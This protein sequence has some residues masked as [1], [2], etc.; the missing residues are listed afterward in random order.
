MDRRPAPTA[1]TAAVLIPAAFGLG[2]VNLATYEGWGGISHWN[3]FVGTLEMGG[4]GTLFEPRLAD[5]VKY[6]VAA[7]AGFGSIRNPDDRV[8]S[9]L[10]A[11]QMYQ[12]SLPVPEP[13]AGSFDPVAAGRGESLFAGAAGCAQCHVPGLFTE[14]GFNMHTAAEIGIDDFQAKRGPW[15]RYRTTP[16]RGL[17]TKAKGGYYHDGRFA[18]LAEVVD[19]YDNHFGLGLAA[20]DKLDL[21][22][23]LKSL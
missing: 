13:P 3:A 4:S 11:L 14:P 9:K 20:N 7:A 22:E 2:G 21:V 1:K 23:Y 10:H 15:D 8:T 6:P 19:H 12:L 5:P 16:L 17:F 18:T